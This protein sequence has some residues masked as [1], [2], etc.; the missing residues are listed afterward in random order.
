MGL[1]PFCEVGKRMNSDSEYARSGFGTRSLVAA[2][3]DRESAHAAATML[4]KEGFHKIWIGVT[5]ASGTEIAGENDSIGAKIGRFFSGESEDSMIETLMRHGV[6]VTEAE[7]VERQ[8]EPNDVILTVDGSNHP[9][10]AAQILEDAR[11]DVLSG[12]SFMFTT[13]DWTVPD[14]RP[15]SELLGYQDPNEYARGK[16]V[17]DSELTR[18]RNER[19]LSDSVPIVREDIFVARYDPG[20]LSGAIDAGES[21]RSSAGGAIG[22]RR[23]RHR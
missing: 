1:H 17:D 19:L 9:E 8:I 22:T 2:F 3:T 15:G 12:E 11:G 18:L 21:G 7:R 6:G 10:L 13:V 20:E 23:R 16:R 5:R 14:D 4:R